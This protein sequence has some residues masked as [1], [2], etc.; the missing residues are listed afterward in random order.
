MRIIIIG[1]GTVGEQIAVSL[2][3]EGH[4]VII[5]E[6]DEAR[7]KYIED[8]LDTM[9][10]VGNG[11]NISTLNKAGVKEADIIISVT[12]S[13]EVNMISSLI[14]NKLGAKKKIIRIK[15]HDYLSNLS[16]FKEDLGIDFIINPA[17]AAADQIEKL[18]LNPFAS[19]IA[20][21]AEGK[22][23]MVKV[24]LKEDFKIVNK[25]I[26]EIE[27][28]GSLLIGA[29]NRNDN[30]IIPKGDESLLPGDSVY[31]LGKTEEIK[32]LHNLFG[33]K[34]NKI[35]KVI[36]VGGSDIGIRLAQNLEKYNIEVKLIEKNMEK[37]SIAASILQR[38]LVINGD[39]TDKELLKREG[40]E[41]TDSFVSLTKNDEDNL[42]FSLLAKKLGAKKVIAKVTKPTYS[43]ILETIGIDAAI[44]PRLITA[45]YI[46]SFI[47]KSKILNLALIK[48][49]EA[50]IVEVEVPENRAIIEIPLEK[51]KLP[52]DLLIAT[53]VRDNEVIIPHGNDVLLPKDKVI[54]ITLKKNIKKI[55]NIFKKGHSS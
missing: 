1:A 36:I 6:K 42:V 52:K 2:L 55:E 13:D 47:R 3:E 25:K 43:P 24:R 23:S 34:E 27:F 9:V 10:L 12:D 31:I 51:L 38:T 20:T 29:I 17:D 32:E 53:I 19:S 37:S 15:D 11:A 4:D 33:K 8:M 50:E 26:K 7:A 49:G 5:I 18:I 16:A 14:S 41:L 44:S 48:E 22:I 40:I 54:I 45:S 39:G 35:L 30:L 21:F 46:L 28:P